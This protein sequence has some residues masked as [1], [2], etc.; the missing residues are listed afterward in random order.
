MKIT[1]I[2]P[3]KKHPDRYNIFIDDRFACGLSERTIIEAGLKINQEIT[4]KEIERLV[5][6][7]QLAKALD[8][9]IRFLS[10]RPRSEKEVFDKLLEKEFDEKVIKKTIKKLKEMG[11]LSNQAFIESWVKDRLATKPSGKKLLRLELQ[12]RGIS[13]EEAEKALKKLVNEKTEKAMAQKALAKAQKKYKSLRGREKEQ[14][15]INY[16]L[17]R[18]FE[19]DLIKTLIKR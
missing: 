15:I 14:K 17:R 5:E 4:L 7:D 2:E 16:L 1:K 6:K 11:Y 18:G 12:Q 10:F 9:A 3:Q 19:W 8:K 13:R